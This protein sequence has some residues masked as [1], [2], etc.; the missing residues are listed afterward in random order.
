MDNPYEKKHVHIEIDHPMQM[1]PQGPKPYISG[2]PT[3]R[4]KDDGLPQ[5]EQNLQEDHLSGFWRWRNDAAGWARAPLKNDGLRQL[6]G[7]F[8][9]LETQKKWK[10]IGKCSEPP[11]SW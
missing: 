5:G 8:W 7:F 3:G 1:G 11:I 4:H 2:S 10:K 6:G 9:W